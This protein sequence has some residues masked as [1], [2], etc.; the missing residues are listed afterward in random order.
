Q[1][2]PTTDVLSEF[3]AELEAL[4][5]RWTER[6]GGRC[7]MTVRSTFID[8]SP[9]DGFKRARIGPRVEIALSV[10]DMSRAGEL[11]TAYFPVQD[12]GEL[13]RG[14]AADIKAHRDHQNAAKGGVRVHSTVHIS[15]CP[16]D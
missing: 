11:M 1:A 6:T 12:A 13:I 10:T 5:R 8:E 16:S 7:D 2:K 14:Q 4:I 15:P 9:V 3:G